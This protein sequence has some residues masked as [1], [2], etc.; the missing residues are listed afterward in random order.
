MVNDKIEVSY[1][2]LFNAMPGSCILLQ[3]NA[4]DFTI[5]AVT[6]GYL[7]EM[8]I[9]KKSL[10]GK[11]IFEAFPGNPDDPADTGLNNLR[12]SLE[13][14]LLHKEP[15]YLPTQRYDLPANDGTFSER[16]WSI[17]NKPVFNSKGEIHYIINT[18]EDI[19]DQIR[20]TEIEKQ[21]KGFEE[22]ERDL[23]SLVLQAPIGICVL[24][25]ASLVCKM[26]N[27]SFVNIAGKPIGEI[28]G[29]MYWDIFAEARPFY[30][31]ALNKVVREGTTFRASEVEVLLIRHGKKQIVNTSFVYE[32]VKD[33]H[34]VVKKVVVWLVDNS[35]NATTLKKVEES[36]AKYQTLI[37]SIDN[38]FCTIEVLFN[39]NGKPYN[40]RFLEINKAFERQTGLMNA[41]GQT[42]NDFTQLEDFW[43]E[44]YGNVALT[45]E[46]V[47]FES[48][49]ENLH[50]FYD[51]YAFKVGGVEERIVGILFTDISER[52]QA[53]AV[54]LESQKQLAFAID[55]TEL[56]A[57][58]YN[59]QTHKFRGNDR[60]KEWFGLPPEEEID[61]SIAIDVVAENDRQRVTEAIQKSL[62]WGSN[63]YDIEYTIINPKTG[64]ER[65]VRAK[66][67]ATY[68]EN[69]IAERFDGTLQDVT[70][71][72]NSR[73]QIEQ[74]EERLSNIISQVNAGIAQT[75]TNGQFIEA[76]ER[77]CQMTG[78]SKEELLERTI[79]SITHRDDW[80]RNKELFMKA[81]M[82]EKNFFIEK[83]YIRKD[84]SIVWVNNSVSV[85]SDSNGEKFITAVAIDITDQI[86]NRQMLEESEE[87]F[88]SMADASPVM[89]W[90]LDAEGNSTYY[91][92]RAID[93]T[94]H[95]EEELK[96]GTTWQMAIHPDDFEFAGSLVKNAVQHSKPYQMECRMKRSDGNWRWLLSQGTPR[97]SKNN[98]LLGY[99]GSSIDITEH[100]KSQQELLTALEQMRLSKEAAELGTFDMNM[101]SGSMHW[102][103]RC[104]IL[105]G[106]SHQQPVDF[107]KDFIQNLHV[108]DRERVLKVLDQTFTKSISNGDY[109]VEYRTIGVE[110]GL[111]R[112]VRAKGKVH[113]NDQEK[114]IRFIGSVLDITEKVTAIQRIEAQVEDRTKE[115]AQ[116]NEALQ[117]INNELKRSN[118]NL[119]EFT[120]AA[121]HDLKEP[122]RKIY[123]FT[124][125][126]KDKLSTHLTPGEL[127][128]FGRIEKATERMGNLI[129]DLLLY[130]HVSQRPHQTEGIDLNQK[131]KIVLEDL[132]LNITEKKA[133]INVEK[134]PV[135]KGYKRQLQQLF[136]NLIS[137]ALKY[138]KKD[139]PAH[140]E[141]TSSKETKNEKIYYRIDVKDNGIGFE[142]EYADKIFQMFRRLHG[143]AEY[144]GTGVG[145]SIVK[146]VVENHNG[147]IEV[148][149]S[150][151]EGSTFSIFLPVN[152]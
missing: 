19:T 80:P 25:A 35:S 64:Q 47:R 5:V 51:V 15:H 106:I 119:E 123:F 57:W 41:I 84:G 147:L 150:P 11:G 77:F 86:N 143:K 55:A 17:S 63:D 78:Y 23:L 139:I 95:S 53:E 117:K 1:T 71:Q 144:S 18:A 32:P 114:P 40:Y 134:L 127:L 101:E 75:K 16:Y 87:R 129:D 82:E 49:A 130:S 22:S 138:S 26:V 74:N 56:A 24:D 152:L 21:I 98:E 76:N 65:I 33:I 8:G 29:K 102:D 136:Q 120:H 118:Q 116:A 96:N 39:D 107:Q 131:V 46:A 3:N 111:V 10:I 110:D 34:G 70:A 133:V 27:A 31:E 121:S 151:G 91:N 38:G 145:L 112:W 128:S 30:E 137:N 37:N 92:K 48:R 99:V 149:S 104:R 97:F 122:V 141:I 90:T 20:A 132:E 44:T 100:K 115:L 81:L 94:G 72:A 88:R 6:P 126:L 61:L 79:E 4:P 52:K 125:Q 89:I 142:Q 2:A 28:K 108:D 146:K 42:M 85:V 67:K 140:I 36:Q 60:L 66:G 103:Q 59:P 7:S 124:N 109:D 135:V 13:H 43:Y 83:R 62:L 148:I 113:F 105:F 54:I 69:K 45:G 14:V 12:I 9:T 68:N 58:D 50:R 93:F 73:K